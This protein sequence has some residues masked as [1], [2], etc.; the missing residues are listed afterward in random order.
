MPLFDQQGVCLHPGLPQEAPL[1]FSPDGIPDTDEQKQAVRNM[2]DYLVAK[3]LDVVLAEY[4]PTGVALLQPCAMAGVPLVVHFHGFDASLKVV[5]QKYEKGYARLFDAATAFI[6]VSKEMERDL[7]AMGVPAER[8]T[9]IPCGVDVLEFDNAEPGKASPHFL[10]VGRFVEKKSPDS[11]VRAFAEVLKKVPEATLSFVGDGVLRKECMGLAADLGVQDKVIFTGALSHAEV[12][13]HMRQARCFVQH[14]VTPSSGDKEGTPVSIL[15]ASASGLPVVATRH[16][17]IQ[18]A[19]VHEKTG[20]LCL[21]RDEVAMADNMLVMAKNPDLA[22]QFGQAGRS[23]IMARYSKN[24]WF[25]KIRRVVEQA[26]KP[27]ERVLP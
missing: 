22:A 16:A 26:C 21:E 17:G 11:V 4:G 6:V 1:L 7:V 18:E 5:L 14:S 2:A 20:L 19:V 9:V 27:S 15:E 24:D 10:A 25:D 13:Q 23:H 12:A 3:D 8:V